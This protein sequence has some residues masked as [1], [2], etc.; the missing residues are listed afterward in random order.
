MI[1]EIYKP[2]IKKYGSVKEAIRRGWFIDWPPEKIRY[3]FNNGS[4]TKKDFE[5]YKKDNKNIC[6]FMEV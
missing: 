2:W 1:I 3:T 5:Q 4:G 6:L